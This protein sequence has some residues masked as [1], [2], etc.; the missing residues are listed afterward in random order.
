MEKNFQLISSVPT[1]LPRSLSFILLLC[2]SRCML[3]AISD[4]AKNGEECFDQ[5]HRSL[6]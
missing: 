1:V 4:T 3:P 5:I 2:L 6:V